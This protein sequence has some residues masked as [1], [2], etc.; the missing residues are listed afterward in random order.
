[1]QNSPAYKTFIAYAIR[2]IPPKKATKFKKHA[3]LSKK[4]T[5]VDVKE[6]AEK[7]AKK[8]TARRQSTGVQ[9]RDTPDV[10]VSKKK[11]P[12]KAKR[13]KGIELLSKAALL[14][15]AQV[16]DVS[17]ADSSESEYDSWGDSNDDDQQ[18]DDEQ[19]VSNNPRTS[20]DEEETQED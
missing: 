9:I 1:M 18:S 14:E 20:N 8:P 3:S 10:S 6:P 7:P 16:P 12:A 11:A 2:A 15:E 13:S 19:T 4:K 5:L 17:K